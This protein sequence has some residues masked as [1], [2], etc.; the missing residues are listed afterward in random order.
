M[1]AGGKKSGNTSHC[2]ECWPFYM[3]ILCLF[4]IRL[5]SV[6]QIPAFTSHQGKQVRGETDLVQVSD[7]MGE[8]G[9]S[10]RYV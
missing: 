9:V 2:P 7:S 1:V 3:L 4:F 6:G 10:I 8:P 5:R